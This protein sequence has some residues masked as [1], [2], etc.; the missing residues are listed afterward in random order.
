MP[1][2]SFGFVFF[3]TLVA[4]LGAN[5]IARA[6]TIG[7]GAFGPQARVET[8]DFGVVGGYAGNLVT[9]DATY[10]FSA[11]GGY[12]FVAYD[13]LNYA[14][15]SGICLGNNVADVTWTITLANPVDRVGGFL[16]GVSDSLIPSQSFLYYYDANNVLL[17][18]NFPIPLG[19]TAS[20]PA[21]FG[22]QT[23]A[24]RIKTIRIDPR[25]EPFVTMLDNF[26]FEI[27]EPSPVPL[28]P[29]SVHLFV[30]LCFIGLLAWR[31]R[32][33]LSTQADMAL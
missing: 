24:D 11:P 25:S 9:A 18:S 28:S 13:A 7:P 33:A 27:V 3:L 2:R 1:I 5:G 16:S 29:S 14:C 12:R 22:F 20:S 30:G 19:T 15:V 8:F 6:S 32:R 26:T 21:F 4:S 17:G 10:A 31:R 23:D